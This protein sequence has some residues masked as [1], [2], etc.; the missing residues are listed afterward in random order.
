[1]YYYVRVLL[2]LKRI[3]S[4]IISKKEDI[5]IVRHFVKSYVFVM[6]SV[7]Q[8]SQSFWKQKKLGLY[9]EMKRTYDSHD[10]C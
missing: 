9:A 1:M 7:L 4:I 6:F 3:Y 2:Y 10:T 8:H 5:L